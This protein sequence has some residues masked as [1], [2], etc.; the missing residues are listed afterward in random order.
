MNKPNTLA[1]PHDVDLGAAV[2]LDDLRVL[3][4]SDPNNAIYR[5]LLQHLRNKAAECNR[6]STSEPRL[7]NDSRTF[8]AGGAGQVEEAFWDFLRLQFEEVEV[9]DN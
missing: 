9:G 5:G 8:Y 2:S 3:L 7:S 4:M 6:T 1:F